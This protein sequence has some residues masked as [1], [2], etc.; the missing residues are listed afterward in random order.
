[1][2]KLLLAKSSIAAALV[3][4]LIPVQAHAAGPQL[5]SCG[6]Y[7]VS[8]NQIIAGQEL[9]K[10]KYQIN[11]NGISCSKVL[12]NNGLFKKFLKLKNQGGS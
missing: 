10:G 12:G 7:T 11:A 6:K 3:L 9:P 2:K 1:M 5:P 4:C 8:K